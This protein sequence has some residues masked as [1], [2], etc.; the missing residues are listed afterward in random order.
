MRSN[1]SLDFRNNPVDVGGAE[2]HQH[3]ETASAYEI[4]KVF[5]LAE[6]P[7]GSLDIIED[8]GAVNTGYGELTRR[9][10][11]GHDHLV[12]LRE[13]FGKFG[14]EVAGAGVEVWLEYDAQFPSGIQCLQ[15]R[16]LSI[17]LQVLII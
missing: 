8:Q 6:V 1:Y 5:P 12:G 9:I 2:C 10:D 16:L 14:G 13:G 3:V 7:L 11:L 4:D 15:Y 17:P